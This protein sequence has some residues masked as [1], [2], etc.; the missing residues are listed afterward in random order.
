MTATLDTYKTLAI[1]DTLT[2][3]EDSAREERDDSADVRGILATFERDL[4][5]A[6]IDFD[7]DTADFLADTDETFDALSL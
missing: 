7:T 5:E 3:G 1:L 2:Y 4:K 6:Q